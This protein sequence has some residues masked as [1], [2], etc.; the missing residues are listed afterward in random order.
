MNTNTEVKAE[1]Y[2]YNAQTRDWTDRVEY[3]GRDR[4]EVIRW[5]NF[6][7]DWMKGLRIIEK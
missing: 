2:A 4:M 1:G 7:K 6:N 3:V 5:I